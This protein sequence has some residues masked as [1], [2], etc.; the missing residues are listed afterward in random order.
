MQSCLNPLTQFECGTL[1]CRWWIKAKL[2]LTLFLLLLCVKGRAYVWN[3]SRWQNDVQNSGGRILN[4]APIGG[5][6]WGGGVMG[7]YHALWEPSF[8]PFHCSAAATKGA[9]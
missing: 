6:T 4:L 5:A 3:F 7:N 9:A 1:Q 8:F 2:C